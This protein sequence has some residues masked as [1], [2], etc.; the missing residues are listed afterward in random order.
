LGELSSQNQNFIP[1]SVYPYGID[2]DYTLFKVKN[3]TESFIA[4]D[5]FAWSETI[6]ILPYTNP[7]LAED[8]WPDNGF[9]TIDGELLYYNRVEKDYTNGKVIALKDC[10]RNLGGKETHFNK[11]GTPIRG[12][13][14]AE[15][16]NQLVK[17]LINLEKFVGID[18]DIDQTT[19]D[20]KIRNLLL[21][22]PI[23][24]DYGCPEINFTF[25]ILK[26]DA[27]TGVLVSYNL[28]INGVYSSF[29]IDFGDGESTSSNL[30]GTKI[31]APASNIDPV[32][33]VITEKCNTVQT[34]LERTNPTE[35]KLPTKQQRL[36]LVIPPC[37]AIPDFSIPDPNIPVANI[38][39]PPIVFP[40]IDIP[41]VL[42]PSIYINI[43]SMY[44]NVPSVVS[45]TPVN[46]PTLISFTPVNIPSLISFTNLPVI[47]STISF[48]ASFFIPSIIS[49]VPNI[50]SIISIVPN[51]PSII[52][53][54]PNIPSIIT[55]IGNIPSIISFTPVNI[56]S[57][58]SFTPI[59]IPSIISFTPVNIPS[60]ISFTPVNIP[61][62]IS[63]TPV[64]IPSLINFGPANVPS[65]ISFAPV[66]SFEPVK[67]EKPP[68]FAPV[69]FKK[70]PTIEPVGF[71]KPP[72]I[73]PVGFKK[74]PSFEPVGF[75]NPPKFPSSIEFGNLPDFPC[76]SF[77][78]PP[79]IDPIKFSKPPSIAPIEFGKPPN[80][81]VSFS[82]P[83]KVQVDWGN[84]PSLGPIQFGKTPNFGKVEFGNAPNIP[85]IIKIVGGTGGD[86][87]LPSNI[88][89]TGNIPSSIKVDFGNVPTINVNW[90]TPPTVTC[91]VNVV[92]PSSALFSSKNAN[93]NLDSNNYKKESESLTYD[94][95]NLNVDYDTTSIPSEINLIVPEIND[96][97]VLHDIPE[98][99]QLNV[100]DIKDI[101]VTLEDEIPEEIKVVSDLP[102]II[103]V[104]A[105][106]MPTTIYLKPENIPS[107][108][109]LESDIELPCMI[110]F[111]VGNI[112]QSISITGIPDF[113]E[114]KGNIPS[115]INLKMPEKPEIEMVYKGSPIEVKVEIDYKKIL[116]DFE[117]EDYPCFAIIPCPSKPK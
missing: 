20:W 85:S 81:T 104:D 113:I 67:F 91:T 41:S 57:I 109:R 50:P 115:E 24:D 9:A 43:P 35:P 21:T 19:L 59:N 84:P 7:Y 28:Q 61:S 89:I 11:A 56:P 99:I 33:T 79:Q 70:P 110:K 101:K 63:F 25:T 2:T 92:C 60:V 13:V 114:I 17:A 96:I 86:F 52:S 82:K 112:P 29:T 64:N 36:N 1:Q 54:V 12:F 51:I 18:F 117:N 107:V 42:L 55:I 88:T 65:V 103:T 45:F 40:C 105:G 34:A 94:D 10:I 76:V 95:L 78:K 53:I 44:I 15:H 16:H 71:K 87:N 93:N 62:V 14:V 31:Y 106:N 108:I 38:N 3:T 68:S 100:P 77:C 32:V 69:G 72:S 8:P 48:I 49:I 80:L 47:P 46:I 116:G 66:P 98:Y 22:P 74:P 37:P 111:D 6:F 26:N 58:I 75:K 90:G 39:I 5:N 4:S 23:L 102:S 97:K 83:P 30:S 27:I 73:E